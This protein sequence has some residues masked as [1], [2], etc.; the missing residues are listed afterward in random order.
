MKTLFK[1]AAKFQQLSLR[2][3]VQGPIWGLLARLELDGMV[4]MF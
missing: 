4:P 3:I 1:I 2:Q